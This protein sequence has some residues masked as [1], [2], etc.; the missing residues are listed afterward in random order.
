MDKINGQR[1]LILLPVNEED[2]RP[3]H[4]KWRGW[5]ALNLCLGTVDRIQR[6]AGLVATAP[7]IDEFSFTTVVGGFAPEYAPSPGYIPSS[8]RILVAN[9][10]HG[11]NALRVRSYFPDRSF[12]ETAPIELADLHSRVRLTAESL[13]AENLDFRQYPAPVFVDY[14]TD[15][16]RTRAIAQYPTI[17][18]FWIVRQAEQ[19]AMLAQA[20]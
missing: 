4:P 15:E 6:L 11:D 20:D 12:I 7:E 10:T 13:A 14:W 19:A 17:E 1:V 3:T 18:K 9:D 2:L 8:P 5:F 16:A